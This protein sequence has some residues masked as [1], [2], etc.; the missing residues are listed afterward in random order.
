MDGMGMLIVVVGLLVRRR[1]FLILVVP[2]SFRR[3]LLFDAD[4]TPSWCDFDDMDDVVLRA[5]DVLRAARL[6]LRRSDI[7]AALFAL[8]TL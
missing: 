4:E 7:E 3:R 6:G 5:A 2:P 1:R 8:P